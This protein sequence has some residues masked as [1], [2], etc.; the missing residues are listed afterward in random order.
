MIRKLFALGID[1]ETT[2]LDIDTLDLLEVGITAYDDNLNQI[3]AA[4]ATIHHDLGDLRMNGTVAMMHTESGLLRDVEDSTMSLQQAEEQ[5][6]GWLDNLMK[7]HTPDHAPYV[8]GS[9]IT[10]DRNVLAKYMPEL[11]AK[12]HYRSI[13]ATT[14]KL[15]AE[16]TGVDIDVARADHR[17]LGDIRRSMDI[18]RAGYIEPMQH[19]QALKEDAGHGHPTMLSSVYDVASAP[20]G[21]IAT[22]G[23]WIAIK[24][25]DP[26]DSD[27]DTDRWHLIHY[28]DGTTLDLKN[29][30]MSELAYRV[31]RWGKE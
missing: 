23:N 27:A 4:E 9:S 11:Y 5:L 16:L 14:V 12:L 13:D 3:N 10:F 30:K 24:Y 21:T 7:K 29:N 20:G 22:E 2:D 15:L 17:T 28:R 1:V 18:I 8:L 25:E 19:L 26:D 31:V 6:C